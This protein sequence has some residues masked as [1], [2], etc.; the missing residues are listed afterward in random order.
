MASQ[1][2]LGMAPVGSLGRT[3]WRKAMGVPM[4]PVPGHSHT[5]RQDSGP[6]PGSSRWPST[7]TRRAIMWLQ[8]SPEPLAS[9]SSACVCNPHQAHSTCTVMASMPSVPQT[10]SLQPPACLP[11]WVLPGPLVGHVNMAL[12]LTSSYNF[13]R[14][15]GWDSGQRPCS[16]RSS[17]A[18]GACC[19]PYPLASPGSQD[20]HTCPSPAPTALPAQDLKHCCCDTGPSQLMHRVSCLRLRAV[21]LT[22]ATPASRHGG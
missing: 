19:S 1:P 15:P 14:Q 16:P 6:S 4:V 5:S 20:P 13:S 17:D 12:A 22:Q 21:P 10:L 3:N 18:P 8:V 7:R 11:T 9:R 2:D